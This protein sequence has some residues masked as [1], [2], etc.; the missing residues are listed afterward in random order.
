MVGGGE[1][2]KGC[3][4]G[5]DGGSQLGEVPGHDGDE[6]DGCEIL[7]VGFSCLNASRKPSFTSLVTVASKSLLVRLDPLLVGVAVEVDWE[8]GDR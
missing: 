2:G 8:E 3:R 4:C 7:S 1:G 5:G 6:S